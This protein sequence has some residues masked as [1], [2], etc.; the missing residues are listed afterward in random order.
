MCKLKNLIKR[1]VDEN[2]LTKSMDKI[3]NDDNVKEG[4]ECSQGR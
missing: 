4:M 2:K 3:N 1:N